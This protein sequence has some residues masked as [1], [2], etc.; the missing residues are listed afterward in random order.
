MN[1]Y[2]MVT[3]DRCSPASPLADGAW[4]L[5]RPSNLC[6]EQKC[7]HAGLCVDLSFRAVASLGKT[8]AVTLIVPRWELS[9]P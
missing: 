3:I 8:D 6:V 9:A 2:S 1:E 5:G 7:A 4:T